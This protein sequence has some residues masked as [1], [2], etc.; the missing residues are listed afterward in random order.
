MYAGG[1]RQDAVAC[2]EAQDLVELAHAAV[3]AA[4]GLRHRQWHARAC[5]GGCHVAQGAEE[6]NE[7]RRLDHERRQA[8]QRVAV[9]L[10]PDLR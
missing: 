5:L 1:V 9:V 3:Q 4:G 8:F 2:G 7:D 10:R 6:T